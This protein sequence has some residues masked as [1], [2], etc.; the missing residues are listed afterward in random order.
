MP[1]RPPRTCVHPGCTGYSVDG[2]DYCPEH[3]P[4]PKSNWAK[5]SKAGRHAAGYDSYWDKLR[6]T[7][8]A[9]D[10]YLCQACLRLGIHKEARHVDHVVAKTFG[11]DN[12]P[13]NLQSLCIP[14]HKRKTQREAALK[15]KGGNYENR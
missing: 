6:L 2:G 11:G 4:K 3:K 5:Y 15:K 7:I 13:D 12:S 8:L 1:S 14:C 9:R 10:R